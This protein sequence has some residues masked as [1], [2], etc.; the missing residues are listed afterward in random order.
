MIKLIGLFAT[1]MILAINPNLGYGK[2]ENDKNKCK[3]L[4]PDNV[5]IFKCGVRFVSQGLSYNED[6]N[7]STVNIGEIPW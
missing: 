3:V 4:S 5:K 7:A 2:S 6:K 1:L